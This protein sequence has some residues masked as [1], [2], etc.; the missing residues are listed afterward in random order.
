MCGLKET[1]FWASKINLSDFFWGGGC[2]LIWSG[3]VRRFRGRTVA[4]KRKSLIGLWRP[5]VFVFLVYLYLILF[6]PIC[7]WPSHKCYD[8]NL[9]EWRRGVW[10]L[11]FTTGLPLASLVCL[12]NEM[13]SPPPL[14]PQKNNWNIL[15]EYLIII[16]WAA[17]ERQTHEQ[18]WMRFLS[19]WGVT[20]SY[21]PPGRHVSLGKLLNAQ[22]GCQS[23][24][25]IH[26][27]KAHGP[28]SPLWWNINA[29][30][31]PHPPYVCID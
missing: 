31:R 12:L 18:R 14:P 26:H 30:P 1:F 25:H 15:L 17:S 8:H 20:K 19:K 7:F 23:S 9:S 13:Q 21:D 10:V 4:L 11:A 28:F 29:P 22:A 24:A 5:A 2:K 16:K 27:R 3:H 6:I